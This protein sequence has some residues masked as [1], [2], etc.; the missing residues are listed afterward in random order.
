MS[1]TVSKHVTLVG[2]L[3]RLVGANNLMALSETE[4]QLACQEGHS[5]VLQV[6]AWQNFFRIYLNFA[7]FLFIFKL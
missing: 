2:E 6:S 1:G 4:Q 5:D 3:S 7:Y